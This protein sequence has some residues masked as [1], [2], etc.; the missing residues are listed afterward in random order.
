[1]MFERDSFAGWDV[2]G[3]EWKAEAWLKGLGI[4]SESIQRLE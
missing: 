3:E 1:M 4:D 2:G